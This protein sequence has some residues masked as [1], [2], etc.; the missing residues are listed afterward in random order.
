[1][2]G[3][4]GGGGALFELVWGLGATGFGWVVATD[5]RGAA[6]RLHQL[7]SQRATGFSTLWGVGFLRCLA[8]VFGVIGP[9]TL[10]MAVL[11]LTEGNAVTRDTL[12]LPV[13]F[14]VVLALFAAFMLWAMWRR[15]GFLRRGWDMGTP[16]PRA[17]AVVQT[18]AIG[19]FLAG[20]GL[21]HEVTMLGSWL[22]GAGAGLFLLVAGPADRQDAPD[23]Q[24]RPT[25]P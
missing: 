12:R 10:V 13:P 14:L 1:M 7:Q 17:A 9:I 22:I 2:S 15:N 3:G 4:N 20:I 23:A 8:G 16:V 18:A 6:V 19:G 21:G 5:F 24:D 25:P 11:Q